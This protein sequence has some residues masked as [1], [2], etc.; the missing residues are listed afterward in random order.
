MSKSIVELK[1]NSDGIKELLKSDEIAAACKEQ[2]DAIASRAGDGY[3]VTT[4]QYPERIAYAVNAETK[5]ARQ[6]NLKN[7]TL[8]KALGT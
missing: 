6:D 1:L 8:L 7:N 5:E 3:E 2:A 4:R